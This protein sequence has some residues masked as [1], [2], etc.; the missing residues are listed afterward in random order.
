M[1]AAKN[2][3]PIHVNIVVIR[4]DLNPLSITASGGQIIQNNTRPMFIR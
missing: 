2:P 4:N 1:N 3:S